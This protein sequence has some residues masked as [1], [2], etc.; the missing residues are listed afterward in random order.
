MLEVSIFTSRDKNQQADTR[1]LLM[2][3]SG[4]FEEEVG[5]DFKH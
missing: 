3:A 1:F 2:T 4:Y 5:C